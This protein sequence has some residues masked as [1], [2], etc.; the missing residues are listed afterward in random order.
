[1][2]QDFKVLY[3]V[4]LNFFKTQDGMVNVF[5]SLEGPGSRASLASSSLLELAEKVFTLPKW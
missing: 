3:K 4:T 1:M 2:L 5:Q